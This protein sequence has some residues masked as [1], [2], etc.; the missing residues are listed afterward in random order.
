M[1]TTL[2][3][4]NYRSLRHLVVPLGALNIVT[5]A[6]GSGKSNL[7]R[8]LRL[9]ADCS[10]DGA[11]AVLAREG[12]LPSVLWAGPDATGRDVRAGAHPVQGTVRAGRV[13]LRLGFAG[14]EF[15]YAIDFGLPAEDET[16]TAFVRDPL[17]KR[18]CIWTG[19][20]LRPASLLVDRHGDAVWVREAD[21]T[22]PDRP[23][24]VRSFD[25]MLSEFAD[26]ARAPALLAVRERVRSWRFYHHF[27]TDD[28]GPARLPQIGTRTAVLSHDGADLAAAL[29]T[30]L[31][32]GDAQRLHE[33]VEVAF[34][35]SRVEVINRSGWFELTFHQPGLL[36]RLTN[37]ELS[38]GTLRYLLW[39]AALLTPRPPGAAHT[40][41]AGNQP[42]PGPVRPVGAADCRCRGPHPG[43]G[44]ITIPAIRECPGR[45]RI[46]R[47]YLPAEDRA[48]QGP[49][50]HRSRRPGAPRRAAVAVANALTPPYTGLAPRLSPAPA[51]KDAQLSGTDSDP[52]RTSTA[53]VPG[54]YFQVGAL[55][56]YRAVEGSF[57]LR[58]RSIASEANQGNP[59]PADRLTT[60]WPNFTYSLDCYGVWLGDGGDVA[61]VEV[62]A[63]VQRAAERRSVAGENIVAGD[64]ALLNLGDPA[65]GDAHP[66]G[67]LLLGQLPVAPDLG[68]AVSLNRGQQFVLACCYGVF[69]AGPLGMGSADILPPG[70]AGHRLSSSSA[71][72]SLRYTA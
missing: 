21:G 3:V 55:S 37:A 31:E 11:A 52:S 8:A 32:I 69:A 43:C 2:A 25:S 13:A 64:V 23:D 35:G 54:I 27:R 39:I 46:S 53:G 7:Y 70:V 12:G 17:I 66:I 24:P 59:G 22:W 20:V 38:D 68:Q 16:K 49:L 62:D 44:R 42:A 48:D 71:C 57:A 61:V 47:R 40:Q 26:P 63:L 67:D 50:R 5:G 45:M 15:G 41:R 56:A 30:I 33:A 36:R 60:G 34:P 65:L 6:N 1:L 14:D 28:R 58:N 29:Q 72:R 18:E 4:Q 10:R 9:L 19:P 51:G